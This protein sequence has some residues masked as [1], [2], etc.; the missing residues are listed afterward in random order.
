MICKV[1]LEALN[2]IKTSVVLQLLLV[3]SPAFLSMNN[4]HLRRKFLIQPAVV[5]STHSLPLLTFFLIAGKIFMVL[6]CALISR[7]P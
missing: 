2:R 7:K 6:T 1:I 5:K 3:L 4:V